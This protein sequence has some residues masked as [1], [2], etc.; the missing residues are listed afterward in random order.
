MGERAKIQKIYVWML[1]FLT[2]YVKNNFYIAPRYQAFTYICNWLTI[3]VYPPFSTNFGALSRYEG[4]GW[5]KIDENRYWTPGQGWSAQIESKLLAH[6]SP[7]KIAF[8]W[9]VFLKFCLILWYH[10]F[11]ISPSFEGNTYLWLVENSTH[12]SEDLANF[13]GILWRLVIPCYGVVIC[14][15]TGI[16]STVLNKTLT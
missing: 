12:V 2:Q 6:M 4:E 16:E 11:C 10:T 1:L 3:Y 14:L 15:A 5:D 13:G 9:E 8:P 7:E